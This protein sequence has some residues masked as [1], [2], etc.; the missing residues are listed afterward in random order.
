MRSPDEVRKFMGWFNEAL[1]EYGSHRDA[2]DATELLWIDRHGE[3]CYKNYESF[4]AAKSY[5]LKNRL[6]SAPQQ[7]KVRLV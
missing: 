3:Q 1:S 7:V 4:K 2:Y 6:K 5:Y